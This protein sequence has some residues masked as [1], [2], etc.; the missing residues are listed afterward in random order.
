M[1]CIDRTDGE[2][3]PTPVMLKQG[4]KRAITLFP[5]VT[6]VLLV[7]EVDF[8]EGKEGLRVPHRRR[9]RNTGRSARRMGL[10]SIN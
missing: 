7:K 1:Y 6:Q 8:G 3:P 9:P 5:W 2:R 4:P 10:M